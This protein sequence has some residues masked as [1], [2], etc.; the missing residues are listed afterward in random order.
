MRVKRFKTSSKTKLLKTVYLAVVLTVNKVHGQ[1]GE[2]Q[3]VNI[4]KPIQ[5]DQLSTDI[6]STSTVVSANSNENIASNINTVTAVL[7]ENE[8]ISLETPET[9]YNDQILGIPDIET[10]T[11]TESE[12]EDT[13]CNS[14]I[15]ALTNELQKL[16]DSYLKEQQISQA[17]KDKMIRQTSRHNDMILA[18]SWQYDQLERK[19]QS[20]YNSFQIKAKTAAERRAELNAKKTE[21][22]QKNIIP[23]LFQR[24]KT[25]MQMAKDAQEK[26]DRM[27]FGSSS[28][29]KSSAGAGSSD[30]TPGSAS[31]GGGGQLTGQISNQLN[32]MTQPNFINNE[33]PTQRAAA[34]PSG[35]SDFDNLKKITQNNLSGHTLKS[36]LGS[37]SDK[38]TGR[39]PASL[40][41]WSSGFQPNRRR[42][43]LLL[44]KANNVK[45]KGINKSN[46]DSLFAKLDFTHDFKRAQRFGGIKK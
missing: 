24:S 40:A 11:D 6:S 39:L 10:D 12:S 34:R 38:Q 43:K 42:K 1:D 19:A 32:S 36:A 37:N 5:T 41:S 22:N 3:L 44:A 25:R 14:K 18:L 29:K 8:N 46:A 31:G 2:L 35:Y 15:A 27:A 21:A 23:F 16:K 45:S 26:A 20:Y 13:S 30:F 4:N 7:S 9:Q 17:L 33:A 28:A